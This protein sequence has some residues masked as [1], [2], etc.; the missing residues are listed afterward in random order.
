MSLDIKKSPSFSLLV[1]SVN[2]PLEL[3]K[4]KFPHE[5]LIDHKNFNYTSHNLIAHHRNL[6]RYEVC[7]E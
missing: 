5:T 4:K 2:Q 7:E 1:S 3:A 6:M